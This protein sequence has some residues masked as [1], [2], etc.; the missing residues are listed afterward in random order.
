LAQRLKAGFSHLPILLLLDGL[1]PNGPIIA[2][3]R[4]YNWLR[5]SKIESNLASIFTWQ[6]LLPI[7]GP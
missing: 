6:K 3:C 4:Q 5:P 7:P 1:Y 2:L